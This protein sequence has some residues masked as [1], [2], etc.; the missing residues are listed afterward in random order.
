MR[1]ALSWRLSLAAAALFA[2]CGGSQP[3]IGAPGAIPQPAAPTRMHRIALS[4][5]YKL[6]YKFY[7][8]QDG[9]TPS[10]SLLDVAGTLYGV[11]NAGGSTGCGHGCGTVYT[12]STRGVHKLF[13]SFG[14]GPDGGNPTGALIYVNGT[15]YGTT[16]Y[17]G[18]SGCGVDQGCG[19][20][21]SISTSGSE[22]VLYDFKGGADG[23][24]PSGGLIDVNG[25][26]YGTTAFGGRTGCYG[27]KYGCGTVFSIT[28]SGQ[29][30]V[31]HTFGKLSDG[32]IPRG[33][34][35]DVHGVL[36]GTTNLGGFANCSVSSEYIF[37]CGTI[38][39]ISTSGHEK[40][41]HVFQGGSD[42]AQP[43][44]GLIGLNGTLYGTTHFG[45]VSASGCKGVGCGT[46][47]EIRP[48]GSGYRILYD[49][50]GPPDGMYPESGLTA[51]QGTLY[52]VT[53][54]GGHFNH[55]CVD[56]YELGCGT[57]YSVSTSGAETVLYDF[58]GPRGGWSPIGTLTDVSGGLYGATAFGGV[59]KHKCRCHGYG[60]IFR[61]SL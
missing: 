49:F 25:T 58:I 43:A 33:E 28:T 20:V 61:L 10:G 53:W 7:P 9:E 51:V 13:Y 54:I 55:G 4:S 19:T 31:L 52:G 40:V 60:T 57:I 8:A 15:L 32:A 50:Q 17:G 41:L 45:G 34:L 3:P 22:K 23:C 37:R 29:E 2:G 5:S 26:L 30:S 39:K 6:L 42:G 48:S 47:F 18:E 35:L 14:C 59:V 38:Y 46:V 16:K 21:Y 1:V 24:N 44:A 36:Y 56:G 27:G 11:T 12:V